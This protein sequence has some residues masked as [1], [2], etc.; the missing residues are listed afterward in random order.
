LIQL[1]K[2]RST[3]QRIYNRYSAEFIDAFCNFRKSGHET[4]V[5][6]NSAKIMV[7]ITVSNELTTNSPDKK[8][9]LKAYKNI[10]SDTKLIEKAIKY[11]QGMK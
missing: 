11:Y 2:Y 1:H 10:Q 6:L 3:Y 7:Q 8:M 9:I 5:A 4:K